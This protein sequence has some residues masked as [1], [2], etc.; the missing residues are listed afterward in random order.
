MHS[1]QEEFI[2]AERCFERPFFYIELTMYSLS[3]PINTK[4]LL[5]I[6]R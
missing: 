3:Q 2:S 4:V 5:V 6:H 1:K